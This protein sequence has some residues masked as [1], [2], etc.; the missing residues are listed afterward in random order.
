LLWRYLPAELACL[1]F[2][3]VG[4]WAGSALA[5]N[6]AAAAIGATWAEMVGYYL[7]IVV[8][9]LRAN[10]E[11]GLVRGGFITARNIVLEFG[12]ASLLDTLIIRPAALFAA[13][14]LF[15]NLIVGII[16]GELI[17][18]VLFYVPTVI[19]YELRTRL[20]PARRP[21][22]PPESV[23]ESSRMPLFDPDPLLGAYGACHD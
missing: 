6:V 1:P 4:G 20:L 18:N 12:P 17:A 8:R 10:A 16:V 19:A 11:F 15:S 5:D 7:V 21:V 3:V 23:A 22:A 13:M 2:A 14:T 9:D